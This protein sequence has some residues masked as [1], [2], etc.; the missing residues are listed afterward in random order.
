MSRL[1]L[2]QRPLAPAPLQGLP[3]YYGRIRLLAVHRRRL[4]DSPSGYPPGLFGGRTHMNTPSTG[5]DQ[6]SLGPSIA[7]SDHADP[8]HPRPAASGLPPYPSPAGDVP[9]WARLRCPY[10]RS[11]PPEATSGSRGLRPGRLP[12]RS[13]DS[14]SRR[15]PCALLGRAER[16]PRPGDL[17]PMSAITY[18]AR[19]G[20]DLQ[21]GPR[22][23]L[24][25]R[26]YEIP[27]CFCWWVASANLA[28]SF[29]RSGLLRSHAGA[30]LALDYFRIGASRL[31]KKVQMQGGAR[32]AD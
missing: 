21:V 32:C 17:H 12:R 20:A 28:Q 6:I 29:L 14:A 13:S 27:L 4:M 31:L 30:L 15:T 2:T 7:L 10:G 23:G 1:S 16:V 5:H 25:S 26:P 19:V 3:R 8:N 18:Q 22:A 24:K 11:P 9:S